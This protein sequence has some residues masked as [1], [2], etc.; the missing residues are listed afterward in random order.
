[1]PLGPDQLLAITESTH[2]IGPDG[3]PLALTE[4]RV[5][6]YIR[7]KCVLRPDGK[8]EAQKIEVL[9]RFYE[10]WFPTWRRSRPSLAP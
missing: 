7:E 4:I 3:R 6:D 10:S 8:L 1:M 9:T 2:I 5:G